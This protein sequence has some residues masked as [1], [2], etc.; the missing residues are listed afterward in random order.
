MIYSIWI[1]IVNSQY[2]TVAVVRGTPCVYFHAGY[3]IICALRGSFV[4]MYVCMYACMRVFVCLCWGNFDKQSGDGIWY[5]IIIN[6]ILYIVFSLY[7]VCILSL[8][9]VGVVAKAVAVAVAMRSV[10]GFIHSFLVRLLLLSPSLHSLI[11]HRS[12]C[13]LG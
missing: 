8:S 2:R 6:D 12:H 4:C 1:Y 7:S 11:N 3:D 10:R 13:R 9:L 5:N